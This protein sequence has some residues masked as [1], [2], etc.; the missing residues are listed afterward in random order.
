M[1]S[2]PD[3]DMNLEIRSCRI[4]ELDR[5]VPLLDE[6]FIFG[7]RR[8]T[9]LRLRFPKVFCSNNLH[10]IL[11]C[12]VG[13]E[14][15]AAL[16]MFPFDWREDGKILRGA[17][18][19]AVYTQPARRKQGL[20]SRLLEAAALQLH[21]QKIDFGVLWTGQPAFYAR[22]GWQAADCSVLGEIDIDPSAAETESLAVFWKQAEEEATLLEGIRRRALKATTVRHAEDYRQL[23]IPAENL[24]LLWREDQG[25]VA[26]ALLGSSGEAGFLYELVGDTDC[27]S[28]LW[29]EVCRGR[30]RIVINDQADSPACHWLTN[31]AGIIWQR[32]NL[33]MWLPVSKH[34]ETSRLGQW[35]IPYF[36]RI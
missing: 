25:K 21:E 28:A 19:G 3:G 14:I 4:A 9:S 2:A 8:T 6:E 26:Y 12:M 11:I 5:L 33:T 31:H 32:K 24:E 16:A 1:S 27:F 34:V 18:I 7:K 17:M 10:N 20:A 23:P 35:H 36:D 29:R 22:L 13:D 30:Q 15:A